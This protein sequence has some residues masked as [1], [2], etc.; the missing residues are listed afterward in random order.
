MTDAPQLD[1]LTEPPL[2][3]AAA[4][5]D[6]LD[7]SLKRPNWQRDALRRLIISGELSDEDKNELYALCLDEQ[8]AFD[9]L[10]PDHVA[11]EGDASVAVSLKRIHEPSGVNALAG[12]QSLEFEKTGLT[13]VYG[14]NG[15]GKSGY[16]RIL[17]HACRSRDTRF[18]ILPDINEDAAAAQSAKIEFWRGDDEGDTEWSPTGDG[19]EDLP[20]VSVFDSKSANTHVQKTNDVAYIP[21]PMRLLEMLASACDDIKAKID[22]EAQALVRETPQ[23]I[24]SPE[25]GDQTAAGAFLYDLGPKSKKAEL[26]LLTTLG[27]DDE[28]RYAAL[29]TDLAQDPQKAIARLRSQHKAI[30]E[31]LIDLRALVAATRSDEVTK[32]D[33]L[34]RKRDETAALAEAASKEL[35]ATSPLPD[36][37]GDL[38][39]TLWDSARAYSQQQANPDKA[40]PSDVAEGDL[41][42]LCHQPLNSE[43]VKRLA[44][45]E[46]F[47]KDTTAAEAEKARLAYDAAIRQ[48]AANVIPLSAFRQFIRAVDQE[49]DK[50]ALAQVLRQ[51]GL[52]ALWR[53]RAML[54][55]N[56]P[57]AASVSIDEELVKEVLADFTTRIGQLGADENS[58]ARQAMVTEHRELKDRIALRTLKADVSAEMKRIERRTILTAAGKRAAKKSITTKNKDLSDRLVTAALRDRFAREVQKLEIGAMPIELAKQRDRNAQSFFRVQIV[59]HPDVPVGEVLSEGEHRCVALAAFLA[60]LVTST[61]KSGIVFDDPMSSLDHL[62]RERVARRLVEEAEHRQVVVFTHDLT[63]LF[64][65]DKQASEVGCPVHYRTVR[66]KKKRPG[67]VENDLPLKAKS[68]GPMVNAIQSHLKEIKGG[69]DDWPE[70]RRTTTAKGI[71]TNLREA[72]EQG[73]ADFC[74]P[75]LA[76][77]DSHVK[78]GSLY[79]LLV[80]TEE[81]VKVISKA[82]SRLST[83]LHASP[84]TL[85]PAEV[86]HEDLDREAKLLQGWIADWNQRQ[87]DAA[88]I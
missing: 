76:R 37:G 62:Y 17:K 22:E 31:Q 50:S 21:F 27:E 11:P 32:L 66:R 51:A 80:L 28:A 55:E 81:D 85:N 70:H 34:R 61:D 44:T 68:S 36:I 84:E 30:S 73:I 86:E 29:Q 39:K 72:W 3:E 6:I 5:S 1:D 8:S 60:E 25:L 38:W 42:V 71:I 9:P 18:E 7:W 58:E 57:K 49:M 52:I 16:C 74:R 54:N 53:R 77:F 87:K 78:P 69:F 83:D 79:K 10:S 45:F 35:F 65:I 67:Y 59:R 15:S 46:A 75:V 20:A 82:R 48:L 41:C 24:A 43:A 12:D 13:L 4:L 40:F 56:T 26:D 64:E 88:P 14:D 63:F 19:H 47:I 33:D 23:A 2:S